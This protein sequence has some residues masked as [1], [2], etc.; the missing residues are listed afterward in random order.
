ML[1]VDERRVLG[2]DALTP[3][4]LALVYQLG[5]VTA[6]KRM[7][8]VAKKRLGTH[9]RAQRKRDQIKDLYAEMRARA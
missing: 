4:V 5:G 7:Y 9:V 2:S 6:E 3:R 1:G 8:K